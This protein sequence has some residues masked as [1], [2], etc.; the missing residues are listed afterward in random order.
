MAH[1]GGYVQMAVS[2]ARLG[3]KGRGSNDILLVFSGIEKKERQANFWDVEDV[4]LRGEYSER[5]D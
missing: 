3:A 5:S 2:G 1:D 4:L